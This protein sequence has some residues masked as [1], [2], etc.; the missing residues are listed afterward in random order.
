MRP[1]SE[2]AEVLNEVMTLEY[3]KIPGYHNFLAAENATVSSR[4]TPSKGQ[5][6]AVA[7]DI[8]IKERLF[9]ITAKIKGGNSGGPVVARNGSV[10][11]VSVNLTEGE[12]DYDNLGYGTAIPIYLLDELINAQEKNYLASEQ[13]EFI[14]FE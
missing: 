14:D 6:A 2:Q 8:W 7:E 5:I 1:F 13:I 12:G 10:V 4:Y 3:P 9:L 11:G